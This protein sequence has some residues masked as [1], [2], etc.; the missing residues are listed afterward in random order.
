[1]VYAE[2]AKKL[3][4]F[5]ELPDIGEPKSFMAAV[6]GIFEQFPVEVVQSVVEP[7]RGLPSRVRKPALVD[8]RSACEAAYEPLQR[9]MA[10][11]LRREEL[12]KALGHAPAAR[13]LDDQSK[14]DEH[15]ERVLSAFKAPIEEETEETKRKRDAVH[16]ARVA[17]DERVMLGEYQRHGVAPIYA[18]DMLVSPSLARLLGKMEPER[19]DDRKK[20]TDYLHRDTSI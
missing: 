20:A 19:T 15:V 7:A 3:F 6:I 12:Q 2:A 11:R 16:N 13:T 8:I 17:R 4:Q 1:V 14:V 9:D 18:G 10:G 5:C